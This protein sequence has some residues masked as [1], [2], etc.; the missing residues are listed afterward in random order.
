M[1]WVTEGFEIDTD[2]FE[3]RRA[4]DVVAIEPLVFEGGGSHGEPSEPPAGYPPRNTVAPPSNVYTHG[5][6]D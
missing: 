4:G 5:H 2:A 1:L 6:K 3:L